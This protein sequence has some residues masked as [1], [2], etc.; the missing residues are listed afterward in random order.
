MALAVLT[1]VRDRNELLARL[2]EGLDR[3][4]VPPAELVVVRA[5]GEDPRSVLTGE[6]QY[7]VR[8][9][10]LGPDVDSIDA[11]IPYAPAR[12]AAAAAA[13]SEHLLFLDADTIPGPTAVDA[14]DA[15]LTDADA[16]VIGD[17]RY[18]PGGAV[19]DGWTAGRLTE[20][21]R[22]HPDRPVPPPTGWE[23]RDAHHLLWGTCFGIRRATFEAAGGF[24]ERFSGYAGED[25]DLAF[26]CRARGV[27]LH[28]VGEATVFHQHHDVYEPPVQQLRATVENA[29]CFRDNHGWWPMEGWLRD[30]EAMGLIRWDGDEVVVVRDPTAEEVETARR[31]T[32]FALRPS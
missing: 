22:S 24:D 28:V 23:P 9:V 6:R 14:F 2:V 30:F 18:L 17:I 19:G 16:L 12:N 20:L 32:A 5:G 31:S 4:S 29:R 8:V 27:P 21:G 7:P 13:Q 25:T 15:A 3:S 11:R 26:R 10:D 1:L